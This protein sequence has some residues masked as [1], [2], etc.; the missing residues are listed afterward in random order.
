MP[1]IDNN[2]YY[3][4]QD[5]NVDAAQVL[6]KNSTKKELTKEAIQNKKLCNITNLMTCLFLWRS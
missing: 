5:G 3:T 2:I 4:V 6:K 1:I